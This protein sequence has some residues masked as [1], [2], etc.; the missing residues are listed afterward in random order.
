MKDRRG[1]VGVLAFHRQAPLGLTDGVTERV[2]LER[3]LGERDQVRVHVERERLRREREAIELT[4]PG[5]GVEVRRLEAAPARVV[6]VHRLDH[7]ACDVASE[8]LVSVDEEVG[9][10]AAGH[11][12]LEA[13]REHSEGQPD[14]VNALAVLPLEGLQQLTQRLGLSVVVGVPEDERLLRAGWWGESQEREKEERRGAGGPGS[15][16]RKSE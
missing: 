15:G 8:P 11:C 4:F 14:R 6:G 3:A 16:A 5:E 1:E 12:R 10:I 2:E 7:S 9:A 13:R